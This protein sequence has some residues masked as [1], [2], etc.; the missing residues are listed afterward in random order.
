M[1]ERPEYSKGGGSTDRAG[2]TRSS[3]RLRLGSELIDGIIIN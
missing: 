2:Q 3:A 1:R